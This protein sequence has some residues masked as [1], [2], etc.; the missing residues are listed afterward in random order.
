MNPKKDNKVEN[1]NTH[2]CIVVRQAGLLTGSV[3]MWHLRTRSFVKRHQ[4]ITF[5]PMLE[6]FITMLD[7]M[8]AKDRITRVT[9]LFGLVVEM[10][11]VRLR[12]TACK[13]PNIEEPLSKR[14][15]EQDRNSTRRAIRKE[16]E[17]RTEYTFKMS[18][19]AVIRTRPGA[20]PVIKAEL[21]QMH[22]KS[23]CMAYIC[24]T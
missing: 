10:G 11:T 6:E 3:Q 1:A 2:G 19:Q 17:N 9:N 5:L 13:L 24:G 22:D 8:A 15:T 21:Q 4:F 12:L 16:L 23:V 18:F 14:L 20:L 7:A